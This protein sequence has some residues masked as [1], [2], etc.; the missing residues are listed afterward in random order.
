MAIV[1]VMMLWHS[2]MVRTPMPCRRLDL[3]T[4]S[5]GGLLIKAEDQEKRYPYH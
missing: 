1:V 2:G 3:F 4:F 5:F